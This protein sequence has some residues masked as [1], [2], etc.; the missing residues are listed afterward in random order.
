MTLHKYCGAH[1]W[2]AVQ[3]VCFFDCTALTDDYIP[4]D[5]FTV[6]FLRGTSMNSTNCSAPVVITN[7]EDFEG[8]HEFTVLVDS[9]TPTGSVVTLPSPITVTILEGM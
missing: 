6:T 7:D 3:M 9:I 5:P 8:P 1:A 2:A 4:P